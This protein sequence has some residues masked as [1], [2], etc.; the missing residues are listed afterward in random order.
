M[1]LT[2]WWVLSSCLKSYPNPLSTD[3]YPSYANNIHF[4]LS[5][6]P[7]LTIFPLSIPLHWVTIWTCTGWKRKSHTYVWLFSLSKFHFLKFQLLTRFR[8]FKRFKCQIILNYTT[9]LNS[10]KVTI[11]SK[12]LNE[13]IFFLMILNYKFHFQE[14]HVLEVIFFFLWNFSFPKNNQNKWRNMFDS[15]KW[16]HKQ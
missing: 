3:V 4:L 13:I 14:F 8:N 16:N 15:F 9:Y 10:T 5:T 11:L 12:K 6:S 1:E 2:P 7:F